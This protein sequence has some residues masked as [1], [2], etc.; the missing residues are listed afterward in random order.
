MCLVFLLTLL[1]SFLHH[2]VSLCVFALVSERCSLGLIA[3]VCCREAIDKLISGGYHI[4]CSASALR[5]HESKQCLLEIFRQSH[6][7]IC[8]ANGSLISGKSVDCHRH[9]ILS[10]WTIEVCALAGRLHETHQFTVGIEER[11]ACK[12]VRGSLLEGVVRQILVESFDNRR[13]KALYHR[14]L[15][16]IFHQPTLASY[17]HRSGTNYRRGNLHLLSFWDYDAELGDIIY[18]IGT[19]EAVNVIFSALSINDISR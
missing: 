9:S 8:L 3:F 6:S 18:L 2:L 4:L 12:F 19:N 1:Y 17:C 7:H 13:R 5:H 11:R 10:T 16:V 15:Y 14:I